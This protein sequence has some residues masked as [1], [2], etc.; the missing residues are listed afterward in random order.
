MTVQKKATRRPVQTGFYVQVDGTKYG[1]FLEK[2]RS[3]FDDLRHRKGVSF[4]PVRGTFGWVTAPIKSNWT[5]PDNGTLFDMDAINV[6]K[7]DNKKGW[8]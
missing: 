5:R 2:D 6:F 4:E 3:Q 1:P 7:R 8:R